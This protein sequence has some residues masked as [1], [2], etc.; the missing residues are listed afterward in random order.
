MW[1][2][3][4]GG[5]VAGMAA[6]RARHRRGACGS[7]PHRQL[8]ARDRGTTVAATLQLPLAHELVRHPVMD[9]SE[10][11]EHPVIL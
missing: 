11:A 7:G 4:V 2:F 1:S 9:E 5:E 8:T 6:I 10:P 3:H